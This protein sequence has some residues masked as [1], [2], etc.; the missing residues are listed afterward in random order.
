M[1]PQMT[2]HNMFTTDKNCHRI[3]F[4]DKKYG[5]YDFNMTNKILKHLRY[6]EDIT[7][8]SLTLKVVHM[9]KI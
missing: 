9:R 3:Q 6:I 5:N 8:Y 2:W 1:F 4:N 7:K